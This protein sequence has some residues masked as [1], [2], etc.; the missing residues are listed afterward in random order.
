[1]RLGPQC[2][3]DV[4]SPSQVDCQNKNIKFIQHWE[5]E[6]TEQQRKR[7]IFSVRSVCELYIPIS[8]QR[9]GYGSDGI[10]RSLRPS[11][12]F[13]KNSNLSLVSHLFNRVAAFPSKPALI[14]A[15]SSETL[16]FAELKLL[17]VRVAHGLLRLGVT[18]NDVVLFLAPNDIRYIVC[19][20]AVA[21]L[22]AVRTK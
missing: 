19:F 1:M 21:S 12:V 7:V 5:E 4:V 6:I 10:Y 15:D 13:P 18:K 11:I 20:L 2:I 17:T 8:M 16:S 3:D 14:D 22:G 9:S